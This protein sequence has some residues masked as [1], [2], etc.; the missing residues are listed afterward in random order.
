MDVQLLYNL[1]RNDCTLM[2]P[3]GSSS[4]SSSSSSSNHNPAVLDMSRHLQALM[5]PFGNW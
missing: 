2:G 1:C 5:G 4:S 3:V